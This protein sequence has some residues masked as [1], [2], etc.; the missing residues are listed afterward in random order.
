MVVSR[1][2]G[3]IG[4]IVGLLC[5]LRDSNYSNLRTYKKLLAKV[6][7]WLST[8]EA[9]KE[10]NSKLEKAL[11]LFF[12]LKIFSFLDRAKHSLLNSL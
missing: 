9:E 2:Y 8:L 10:T 4:V 12:I 7:F 5:S 1:L 11:I 3:Y 6:F